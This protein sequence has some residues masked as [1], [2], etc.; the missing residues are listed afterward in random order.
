MITVKIG[1]FLDVIGGRLALQAGDVGGHQVRAQEGRC[2][3]G[4]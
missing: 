4:Q 3:H 2:D 1:M